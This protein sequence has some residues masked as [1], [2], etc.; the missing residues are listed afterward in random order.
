MTSN[1]GYSALV[2]L[3]VHPNQSQPVGRG[4]LDHGDGV[5]QALVGKRLEEGLHTD[6]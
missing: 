6:K 5:R 3:I 4:R 2:N 1:R